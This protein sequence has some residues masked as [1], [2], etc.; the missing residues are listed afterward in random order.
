MKGHISRMGGGV[1]LWLLLLLAPAPAVADTVEGEH[2]IVDVQGTAS[3]KRKGWKPRASVPVRYGMRVLRGDLLSL[4]P[5]ARLTVVCGDATRF[6]VTE[7]SPV[8]CHTEGAPERKLNASRG[9]AEQVP[10]VLSPRSTKLLHARPALRWLAVPGASRYTLKFSDA[11]TLAHHWSTSVEGTEL[12]YPVDAPALLPGHTY[13]LQVTAD[14]AGKPSV[15]MTSFTVLS[16]EAAEALQQKTSQLKALGLPEVTNRF[17]LASLYARHELYAEGLAQ[18]PLQTEGPQAAAVERLRSS[19]Y[20]RIGLPRMAE[21]PARNALKL[22]Q[23]AHD[24][25]GML[26]AEETLGLIYKLLGAHEEWPKRLRSAL[27]QY[28][29]L[30]DSKKVQALEAQLPRSP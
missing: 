24:V 28:R 2:L 5:G 18:L 17:L 27:E 1:G 9:S 20:L 16:P 22:S 10:T 19:L 11:E 3:L 7:T 29:K 4:E 30:G 21:E 6:H 12:A 26:E 25:A 15:D 23:G 8:P 13:V 14:K